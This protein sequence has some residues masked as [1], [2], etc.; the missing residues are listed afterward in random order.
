MA[1]GLLH[2]REVDSPP[3]GVSCAARSI[4]PSSRRASPLEVS[5]R[6]SAAAGSSA[7]G[8]RGS[9]AGMPTPRVASVRARWASSVRSSSCR[10]R[11]TW[12]WR[13]ET[14]ARLSSKPGF[15][16]VLPTNTTVP[17]S[18]YGSRASCW[19]LFHRAISSMNSS[20]RPP[21]PRRC[22]ARAMTARSSLMPSVTAL[23]CSTS[24]STSL[25]THSAIVVLPVP[26]RPPQHHR[27]RRARGERHAQGRIRRRELRLAHDLVERPRPHPLGQWKMA[28]A[29]GGTEGQLVII[30]GCH[31]TAEGGHRRP[32]ARH[33]CVTDLAQ[34]AYR[35]Y[36]PVAMAS[37]F[38][39]GALLAHSYALPGGT[40][41][42]LRLAR[43]RGPARDRGSVRARRSRTEPARARAA[44]AFSPPP[45]ASAVR[46]GSDRRR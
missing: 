7:Y 33:A 8:G 3:S 45:A 9:S 27:V 46:D 41:V 19:A 34:P 11:T 22:S 28:Q 14:S 43:V 42:T 6:C 35:S 32:S 44:S 1:D 40:R 17:F 12:T 21:M 25:A 16:V 4:V 39:P 36:Y 24:A 15:S 10:G 5:R 2:G 23:S 29:Q 38:D 26:G 30:H 18:T 31:G 37:T 20:V 13:R